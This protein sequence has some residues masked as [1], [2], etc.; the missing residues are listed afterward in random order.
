MRERVIRRWG[1]RDPVVFWPPKQLSATVTPTSTPS[2]PVSSGLLSPGF[3]DP[4]C[5]PLLHFP[6][7]RLSVHGQRERQK[8]TLFPPRLTSR[9]PAGPELLAVR[10]ATH[11]GNNYPKHG[12]RVRSATANIGLGGIFSGI[13]FDERIIV[14]S[15]IVRCRPI[16]RVLL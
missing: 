3:K 13:I 10:T 4:S 15:Y 2:P 11:A 14:L 9:P 12:L 6:A 5:T 8:Y 7:G 16:M 1:A